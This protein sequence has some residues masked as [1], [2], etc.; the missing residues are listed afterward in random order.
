MGRRTVCLSVVDAEARDDG[1]HLAFRDHLR[2]DEVTRAP[3]V[4]L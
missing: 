1:I 4:P 2:T 3:K